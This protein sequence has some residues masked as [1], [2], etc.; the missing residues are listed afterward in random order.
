MQNHVAG[1][2]SGLHQSSISY[3]N[4]QHIHWYIDWGTLYENSI[5]HQYSDLLKSLPTTNK[6][7]DVLSSKL[8][9]VLK[10]KR[11]SLSYVTCCHKVSIRGLLLIVQ[12]IFSSWN[13]EK[14]YSPGALKFSLTR[15]SIVSPYSKWKIFPGVYVCCSQVL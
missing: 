7:V 4:S 5:L 12:G 8:I 13:K 2:T 9:D 14:L 11:Y 3:F 6:S 15:A 10:N 1:S